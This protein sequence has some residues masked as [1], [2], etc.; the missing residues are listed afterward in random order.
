M[1]VD[2]FV[3]AG[4]SDGAERGLSWFRFR[5]DFGDTTQVFN[6]G[7]ASCGVPGNPRGSSA[8]LPGYGSVP[9]RAAGRA[10]RQRRARGDHAHRRGPSSTRSCDPILTSTPEA[11]AI[12]APEGRMLVEGDSFRFPDA[13]DALERF[14]A[15][16][17][18]P[19]YTGETGEAV[20]DWVRERGGTLGR[21]DLAAYEPIEREP[22]HAR[23]R[24]ADVLT[25]PPPSSGGILIAHALK[26]LEALG[27]RTGVEQLVRGDGGGQRAAHR[28]VRRGPP[29]RGFRPEAARHGPE[30]G[31]PGG[32]RPTSPLWTRT[33][34]ALGDLLQR[35]RLGAHRPRHGR[36]REQHA[37]RA[38]PEPRRIPP[39]PARPPGQ[40]DDG[41]HRRP[42]R[43]PGRRSASAAPARTES[44]RRS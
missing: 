19:F 30:G 11:A 5:L 12:Y 41:P 27:D 31:Q 2:F 33:A 44:A 17:S 8:W 7:A 14:A 38:G 23:F 4:G 29:R 1:L 9:H 34:C 15:E 20:A 43:R 32:P 18:E 3:A 26:M 25:N 40:L 37:R 16:G 42:A 21:D 10:R 28:R 24:G 13:G 22:V 39:D 6:V 35:H 36:A